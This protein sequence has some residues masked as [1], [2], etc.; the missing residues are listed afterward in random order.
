MGNAIL[1]LFSTVPHRVLPL[2]DAAAG[3]SQQVG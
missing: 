3:S 1:R 2:L